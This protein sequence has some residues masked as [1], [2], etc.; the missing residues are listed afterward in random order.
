[1]HGELV[2]GAALRR[3]KID[4]LQLVLGRDPPFRE[5]G[6]LRLRSRSSLPTSV[7]S[8]L[9][10]LQDLQLGLGDLALRLR[11]RG[12][13]CATLALELRHRDAARP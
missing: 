12:P 7:F 10:E 1:M 3:P 2:H 4:A 6:P 8:V 5:L 13:T 9:V 11:D